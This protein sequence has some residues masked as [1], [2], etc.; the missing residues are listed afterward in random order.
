VNG[1]SFFASAATLADEIVEWAADCTVRTPT[2]R[3]NGHSFFGSPPASA[4]CAT[5]TET[6]SITNELLKNRECITASL[7]P[8]SNPDRA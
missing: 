1:A 5:T 2:T 8:F 3:V 7:F 6:I 4:P